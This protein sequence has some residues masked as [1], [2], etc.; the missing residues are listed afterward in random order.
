LQFHK[1]VAKKME[2]VVDTLAEQSASFWLASGFFLVFPITFYSCVF[3]PCWECFDFEAAVVHEVGH[4]LGLSHPDSVPATADGPPSG[5]P[6]GQNVYLTNGPG[7]SGSYDYS[8]FDCNNPWAQVNETVYSTDPRPSIMRTLTQHNPEVCLFPDDLEA[9]NVLY[10]DCA[11]SRITKPVCYRADRFIGLFRLLAWTFVP[12]V[13]T[14]LFTIG[15]DV[16]IDTCGESRRSGWL[17]SFVRTATGQ[18]E[19]PN[20]AE[21]VQPHG[22]YERKYRDKTD[23]M[24]RKEIRGMVR[25]Y[26]KHLLQ[27][28]SHGQDARRVLEGIH[29]VSEKKAAQ[30]PRGR[31]GS[32][33]G[34]RGSVATVTP[35]EPDGVPSKK[36]I[37]RATAFVMDNYF[38]RE[39]RG[40]AK[41]HTGTDLKVH[42]AVRMLTVFFG[43]ERFIKDKGVRVALVKRLQQEEEKIHTYA[44]D[45]NIGDVEA[46][47]AVAGALDRAAERDGAVAFQQP[48]QPRPPPPMPPMPPPPPTQQRYYQAAPPL[49]QPPQQQYMPPPG[50][51][52]IQRPPSGVQ[53]PPIP[54]G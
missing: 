46:E 16:L 5:R 47:G 43:D 20:A 45:E 1:G 26:L 9:L 44:A 35:T 13:C 17:H 23:V 37:D 24:I 25:R 11:A 40:P 10:P 50:P 42:E 48:V 54:R 53:L 2:L 18:Q 7:A 19:D 31:R 6:G 22:R 34:R 14:M 29:D 4:T 21:L 33:T 3:L 41:Q 38:T 51:P 15:L 27:T 36:T 8:G 12:V 32:I 52:T 39:A 30:N 49:A 28:S